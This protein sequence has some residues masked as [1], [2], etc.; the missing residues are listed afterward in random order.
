MSKDYDVC[1]IGSGAGAGPVAYTLAK[2]GKSVLVLEKGPWLNEKDFTKDEIGICRRD[3]YVP[4]LREEFHTIENLNKEE[5][6]YTYSNQKTGW[7]FW[8]GNMIGGSSNL[9][10]GYFHR[11]K[12]IDFRLLSEFGSIEG[13]NVVDWPISYEDLEPY[14]TKVEDV[15]GVSGKVINHPFQEPRSTQDFPFPP[16]IDHPFASWID[17]AGDELGYHPFPMPRAILTQNFNQRNSCSYSVYC[18]SYGCATGAKG[19]SRAA[20]LDVAIRT[21]RCEVRPNS[22]VYKLES[23]AKGKVESVKYFDREGNSKTVDAKIFVVACQAVETS[24][25]LLMSKGSKHP[26]GLGNNTGQVGINLIFSAGGIGRGEFH[27]KDFSEEKVEEL[28]VRGPFVN[29]A[30]QDWYIIENDKLGR[31]K[32]GTIDFLH[33]HP[34][35]IRKANRLKYG[36]DGKLLWGNE[37][38]EKLKYHF[39]EVKRLYFEVFNDWLPNDN[40]FVELD[41]KHKDKWGLPVAKIRIGFHKHDLKIGNFLAEKGENVLKH[42][43]AKDIYSNIS[44][45]PPANLMAGGCRFGNNPESSVLNPDCQAHDVENLYVTDGSFMP[46]GGS[47]TYTWSIYANAFRVADIIKDRV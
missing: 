38:K 41:S 26:N 17:K 47:V 27:Y 19:S 3:S 28:K 42:L 12:P 23:D 35:A 43:G 29:R 4:N 36:K 21:G 24:R 20:L 46:T 25:L 22:M 30:I 11:M 16:M 6:W 45:G 40:C 39:N 5:E 15:V 14:F 9:M 37:L 10:S 18:G 31:V 7:S 8:N 32:G 34:N 2:A 44:G 1:I 33:E 13:A